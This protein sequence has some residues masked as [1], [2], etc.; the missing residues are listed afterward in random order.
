MYK[1]LLVSD[2]EE[3]LNAFDQIKN[4]EIQG[5]RTPHIR[6]DFEGAKESLSKHHADG[7]AIALSPEEDARMMEYLRE[8]YPTLSVFEAGTTPDEVLRYLTELK[9]Y[10]NR[11]RADFSNDGFREMDLMT[12][13]RRD[14]FRK[15]IHGHVA[16][17]EDLYRNMRL[18][19]S[20]M[21][22][23]RPCMVFR[24]EQN[25]PE[26]RLEGRWHD[27]PERLEL[28]L[29]NSFGSDYEGMHILPIVH[30][31]GR[32]TVLAV[33]LQDQESTSGESM[34]AKMTAYTSD[35]IGHLKEYMGLKLRISGIRVLPALTA[36]CG[37]TT[38]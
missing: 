2:R 22:P 15:L 16:T 7:I 9:V 30:T 38:I 20:R 5:F 17:K 36:L 19:C 33:P 25:I 10:L 28:A 13:C 18:M 24:L 1:L 8:N 3:V 29:R 34:T 32:I 27:G 31:D 26:G 14:Y 6:N 21:D 12:R 23:D 35:S 11:V 37:D 4:W